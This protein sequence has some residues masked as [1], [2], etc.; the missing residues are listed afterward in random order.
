MIMDILAGIKNESLERR[1][2]CNLIR[3]FDS[4]QLRRF[5]FRQTI[6]KKWFLPR[7]LSLRNFKD[8][9]N[10]LLTAIFREMHGARYAS[11]FGRCRNNYRG[12]SKHLF[13]HHPFF[14]VIE[15]KSHTPRLE[16]ITEK[17]FRNSSRLQIEVRDGEGGRF[18]IDYSQLSDPRKI[19]LCAKGS[20]DFKIKIAKIIQE[21]K[22]PWYVS[23][24]KTGYEFWQI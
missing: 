4:G 18:A 13:Q 2:E 7:N 24:G 10:R 22:L 8:I 23:L 16:E 3:P 21:V 1:N 5:P 19:F 15:G 14:K 6:G 12:D 11:F 20:S 9:S 17:A